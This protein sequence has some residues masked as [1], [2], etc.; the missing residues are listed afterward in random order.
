MSIKTDG[1]STTQQSGG[2]VNSIS[3]GIVID[4]GGSVIT[5]GI[6]GYFRV[7]TACTITKVTV[8]EISA[9]PVSSSIVL[10]IWKDTFTN[11]PPTVADTITASAK[12]T[13]S[14]AIKSENS[15]LTGWTTSVS[16]GDT[17]GVNVDS[18]TS[19]VKV[20]MLLEASVI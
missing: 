20:L 18:V 6:K 14:A 5:T 1:D 12:P 8:L 13:L 2:G 19:A 17:F 3:F 16:A 15:T 4:G 10:D 7:P 11:Y 9:T